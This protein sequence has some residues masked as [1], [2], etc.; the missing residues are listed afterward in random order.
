MTT[1]QNY[2]KGEWINGEGVETELF[3]AITGERIGDCSSVG[4]DYAGMIA[5]AKEKGGKALRKMTFTQ[6]GLLLKE[7]AMFL[8]KNKKEILPSF[9]AYRGHTFRFLD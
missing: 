9:G 6:R 7:L 2:V 1:Y 3:N 8:L 5:Y 4:I